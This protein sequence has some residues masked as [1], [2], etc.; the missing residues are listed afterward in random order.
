MNQV[1]QTLVN[2]VGLPLTE[3]IKMVTWTPAHILGI[4]HE[5]GSLAPNMRADIVVLDENL[6]VKMTMVEGRVVYQKP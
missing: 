5:R 3:A 2:L 1:L 4:S 6:S